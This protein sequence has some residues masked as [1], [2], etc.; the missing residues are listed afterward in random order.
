ML[1]CLETNAYLQATP[2]IPRHR[3]PPSNPPAIGF[4]ANYALLTAHPSFDVWS[5]GCILY[6]VRP[7]IAPY[8]SH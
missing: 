4:K 7:Y 1:A 2:L 6:Q 3:N 8:L 5:L